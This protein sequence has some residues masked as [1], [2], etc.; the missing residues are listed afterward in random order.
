MSEAVS[1]PWPVSW[2]SDET[3]LSVI[4]RYNI[5]VLINIV[6]KLET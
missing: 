1:N 6:Y 2:K 3:D 5:G 4:G